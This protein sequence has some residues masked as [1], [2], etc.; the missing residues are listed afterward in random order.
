MGENGEPLHG[1]CYGKIYLHNVV[2][3]C[4]VKGREED[5][6]RDDAKCQEESKKK[7]VHMKKVHMNLIG[8]I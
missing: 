5:T 8:I 6:K 3:Y 2:Q 4:V 1:S 7:I